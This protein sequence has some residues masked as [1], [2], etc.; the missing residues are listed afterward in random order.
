MGRLDRIVIDECYVVLDS[1]TGGSWRL[2]ILGLKGLVKTKTQLVYL[3]AIL[4]L[5]DEAEFGRLV[6]LPG[7]G[8]RWF[9]GAIIRRNVQYR[10]HRYKIPEKSEEEVLI[11]LVE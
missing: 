10:I 1:G 5:A 11:V 4:R 9:R 2:R 8:I 3:T 6:G 7:E